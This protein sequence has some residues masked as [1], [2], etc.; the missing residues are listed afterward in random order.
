M[1]VLVYKEDASYFSCYT[2]FKLQINISNTLTDVEALFS[3]RISHLNMTSN[4]KQ[5]N[6]YVKLVS[7]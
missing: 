7:I 6:K 2:W 5:V 3:I 1:E 4:S